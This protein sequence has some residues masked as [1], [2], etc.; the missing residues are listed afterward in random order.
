MLFLDFL[1]YLKVKIV[2]DSFFIFIQFFKDGEY[3]DVPLLISFS[4]I[5]LTMQ[6]FEKSTL[7]LLITH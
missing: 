4:K 7:K 5:Y 2:I 1:N 3:P 6:T